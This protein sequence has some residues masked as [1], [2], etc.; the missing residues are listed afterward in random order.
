MKC[1]VCIIAVVG[2]FF[3]TW[4]LSVQEIDVEKKQQSVPWG[5][6]GGSTWNGSHR[7][8]VMDTLLSYCHTAI[9]SYCHVTSLPL[10]GPLIAD[11]LSDKRRLLLLGHHPVQLQGC[12]VP[13]ACQALNSAQP[14]PPRTAAAVAA[15]IMDPGPGAVLPPKRADAAAQTLLLLLLPMMMMMKLSY[16][17]RLCWHCCCRCC[18]AATAAVTAAVAATSMILS[19]SGWALQRWTA[20]R[21]A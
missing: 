3:S 5:G 21:W 14:T 16:C 11:V 17:C 20:T 4:C 19:S 12:F 15:T 7:F 8:G 1:H 6:G 10:G 9:L 2:R 18:C 13:T